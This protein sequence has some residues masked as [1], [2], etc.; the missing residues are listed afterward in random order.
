[1]GNMVS[2]WALAVVAVAAALATAG[3][4]AG[5]Q[6]W[7]GPSQTVTAYPGSGHCNLDSVL[8]VEFDGQQYVFDPG[9]TVERQLLTGE[10]EKNSQLPADAVD[11]GLR[12]G[13]S[14]LWLAADG[15]GVYVVPEG[16]AHPGDPAQLWP[17]AVEP[18]GC[19]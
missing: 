12:R 14:A 5:T 11:T 19:D 17:R 2:R 18:I 4:S 1:M 3:C 8:F 15:N 10:P 16:S 7:V 6:V 9:S 13:K